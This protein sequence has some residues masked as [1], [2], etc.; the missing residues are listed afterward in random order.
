MPG[1]DV[2][3]TTVYR[4]PST[5]S[6]FPMPQLIEVS[7]KGNRREFFLWE[8]E[9]PPALKAAV[10]VDADRGEDLGFVYAVGDHAEVRSKGVPHRP[11]AEE[12]VTRVARRVATSDEL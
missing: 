10:I 2:P 6:H 8:G 4:L 3:D 12:P 9:V 1:E 11:T 5:V 7:F